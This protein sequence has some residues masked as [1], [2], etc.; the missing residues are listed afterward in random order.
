MAKKSLGQHFLTDPGILGRIA[1]ALPARPGDRVLE[2]GPGRGGLTRVLLDR[3][4]QVTAIERDRDLVPLLTDQLPALRLIHHDALEV[5]WV[6]AVGAAQGEPWWVIGNIPYNITSPLIDRALEAVPAPAAIVYLV[7]KEVALR[8]GAEAGTEDYGA[9]TVGTQ[10]AAR[11]ERLFRVPAGAFRPPPRVDSAVVRMTP[12]P[13]EERVPDPARF[14]RFVVGLFASRRKQ[15][16]RGLRTAFGLDP[17]VAAAAI[18]E[19]GL[20]PTQRPETLSVAEFRRLETVL[21]DGGQANTL[22][23]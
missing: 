8:L 4:Y 22:A 16:T 12:R 20:D 23:L 11:V 5:D 15:L 9:L 21:V 2:I 10:A 18:R 7:Q 13:A 17:A 1:D 6:D 19:A 3:G 14:R